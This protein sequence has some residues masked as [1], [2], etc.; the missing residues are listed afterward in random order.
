MS[1]RGRRNAKCALETPANKRKFCVEVEDLLGDLHVADPLGRRPLLDEGGEQLPG[2]GPGDDLAEDAPAD[3]LVRSVDV[4]LDGPPEG[5]D[6]PR[7]RGQNL[8]D[9]TVVRAVVLVAPPELRN[10]VDASF[11]DEVT[12]TATAARPG[13]RHLELHEAAHDHVRVARLDE[14]CELFD[15]DEDLA[16]SSELTRALDEVEEQARRVP[17][18]HVS[19]LELPVLHGLHDVRLGHGG[20]VVRHP[21]SDIRAPLQAL[22]VLGADPDVLTHRLLH[23]SP[24]IITRVHLLLQLVH[25]PRELDLRVLQSHERLQ[26]DVHHDSFFYTGTKAC[27]FLTEI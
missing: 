12:V 20:R 4:G 8:P 27:R 22:Q 6:E 11:V 25:L 17:T 19:L 15:P 18:V 16:E 13:S 3:P 1:D 21:L 9:R 23:T 24:R 5:L 14:P 10:E 2:V 26:R 7:T